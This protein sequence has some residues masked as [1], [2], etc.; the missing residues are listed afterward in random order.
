MPIRMAPLGEE[1]EIKRVSMDE[2]AK[3]RLEDMGLVVGQR[4]TVLAKDGGALV[5]RVK[6]CKVAIDERLASGIL[7]TCL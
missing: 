5:I 1:V 7:I 2:D 3:R 4:V 6:D